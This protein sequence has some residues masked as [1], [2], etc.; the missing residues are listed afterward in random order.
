MPLKTKALISLAVAAQ[1]PC[2]YC[3]WADTNTARQAGASNEEIAE[4][5]GMAALTRH[6]STLFNGLQVEFDTFK[7]DLGGTPATQ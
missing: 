2:H 6:W 4:A 5:V 1:I 7:Q 3:V